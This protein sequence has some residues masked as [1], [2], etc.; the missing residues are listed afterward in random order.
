[1]KSITI[2]ISLIILVGGNSVY[3]QIFLDN[4]NMTE[5]TSNWNT[6][7]IILSNIMIQPESILVQQNENSEPRVIGL[8]KNNDPNEYQITI[9]DFSNSSLNF[10][11]NKPAQN[12]STLIVS[13]TKIPSLYLDGV[14]SND[15]LVWDG[16]KNI[17]NWDA[18]SL[19]SLFFIQ[20]NDSLCLPPVSG[21]WQ[22]SSNCV[23][24]TSAVAPANVIIQ[25]NS[26]LEIPSNKFLDINFTANHLL[27]QSGSGV[28]IKSGGKIE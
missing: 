10:T 6:K 14:L 1:M 19:I 16:S 23:L 21:D 13:G 12:N 20:T 8:L 2:I 25:N 18:A 22:I 11:I 24:T 5:N 4:V 15:K 26:V 28:L 3:G 17:I 7:Q 27:I 9:N